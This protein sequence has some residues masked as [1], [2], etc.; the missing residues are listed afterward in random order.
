MDNE[1]DDP[2]RLDNHV[3]PGPGNGPEPGVLAVTNF[4]GMFSC[5]S[6]AIGADAHLIVVPVLDVRFERTFTEPEIK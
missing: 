6:V 2:D 4:L 5:R 1:A 3:R